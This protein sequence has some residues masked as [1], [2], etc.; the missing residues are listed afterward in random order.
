MSPRSCKSDVIGEIYNQ[1]ASRVTEYDRICVFQS[2][3]SRSLLGNYLVVK[4]CPGLV[5]R[6]V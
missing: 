3:L 6:F 2:P 4:V 1:N 5:I